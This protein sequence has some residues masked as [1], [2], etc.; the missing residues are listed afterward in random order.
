MH[1]IL[2]VGATGTVG[3]QVATQLAA[4]GLPVRALVRNAISR[5]PPYVEAIRGDLTRPETLDRALDGVDAVFLVWVAPRDAAEAAIDRIA[6]Y[7]RRIVYLSAPIKTQ[8][9]FFQASLPNPGSELHEKVETLI[10]R[11]GCEWTILR[12][13]MFAA[14]ARHFWGPQIRAGGVIRWPCLDSPT[15]PIDE[16]DVAAFAVEA[17]TTNGHAGADF[18]ITGRESLTQRDQITTLGH[19]VGRSLAIE[20]LTPD[21]WRKM[22]SGGA[23]EP[24]ASI[25]YLLRSW[26]AA[27]GQPT[28]I[29]STFAEVIGREPRTFVEWANDHAAEFRSSIAPSRN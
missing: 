26:S 29:T 13:G 4:Q 19:V 6:R 7:A 27:I 2:V 24:P 22:M 9:P 1:T 25:E 5:L 17:L 12:P 16:R 14:N 15:A 23:P 18:V 10:E 3:R 21:Q 8:H 11:S 20:E 28:F